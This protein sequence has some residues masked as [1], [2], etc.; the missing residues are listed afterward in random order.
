MKK[1]LLGLVCA[2]AI[3]GGIY[4][5]IN[6]KGGQTNQLITNA[7]DSLNSALTQKVDNVDAALKNLTNPHFTQLD[8]L[9]KVLENVQ[10]TPVKDGGDY[11]AESKK[12]FASKRKEVARELK[13]VYEKNNIVTP[14]KEKL[15]EIIDQQ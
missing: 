1:T 3:G 9:A 15:Q 14:E 2:A 7:V 4:Y 5:F 10:W 8:S 11:E 12:N 13:D 6:S